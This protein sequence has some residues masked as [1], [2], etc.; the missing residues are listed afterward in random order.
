MNIAETYEDDKYIVSD[1]ECRHINISPIGMCEECLI[2]INITKKKKIKTILPIIDDLDY[3][4]EIKREANKIYGRLD[5]GNIKYKT[6]RKAALYCL[7]VAHVNLDVDRTPTI[8][9]NDMKISGMDIKK[10]I[11]KYRR[12]DPVTRERN[13]FKQTTEKMIKS[14][15]RKMTI[16]ASTSDNIVEFYKEIVEI[17]EFYE[18]EQNDRKFFIS[19]LIVA[20]M[21]EG[22]IEI[23]E[24]HVKDIF[25]VVLSDILEMKNRI[26][27]NMYGCE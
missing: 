15:C 7:T 5:I 25:N 12:L 2:W 1:I 8:I 9:G 10:T 26:L 14:Y 3:S 13:P 19:A 20:F 18:W 21:E 11:R 23:T 22:G 4:N 6:K 16:T 24:R 17:E 27:D